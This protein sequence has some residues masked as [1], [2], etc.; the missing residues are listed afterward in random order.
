[1]LLRA[2]GRTVA[3][4]PTSYRLQGTPAFKWQGH[5]S[6]DL[7]PQSAF[8]RRHLGAQNSVHACELAV[9][10]LLARAD[11]AEEL[12]LSFELGERAYDEQGEEVAEGEAWDESEYVD[13]G[14]LGLLDWR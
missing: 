12:Q 7:R 11:A 9:C 5:Y 14:M 3:A 10:L 8:L 6:D 13:E 2:D 4:T 1:M